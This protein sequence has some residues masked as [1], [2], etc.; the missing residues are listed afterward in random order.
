MHITGQRAE[1][2]RHCYLYDEGDNIFTLYARP[3]QAKIRAF[4]ECRRKCAIQDGYNFCILSHNSF[5]F[6]CGW[7]TDDGERLT[8]HVET[9]YN[10]YEMEI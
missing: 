2:F 10:S 7:V 4:E 8:L 1:R 5:G 6:T 3:S 9:P